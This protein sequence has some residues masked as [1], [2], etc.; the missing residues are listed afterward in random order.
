M[1]E[2]ESEDEILDRI[3]AALRKIGSVAGAVVPPVSGA[4]GEAVD[5]AALI[6]RLDGIIARLRDGLD[7]LAPRA[8]HAGPAR[9]A[10]TQSARDA[11]IQSSRDAHIQ[12][13]RDAHDTPAHDGLD[14]FQPEPGE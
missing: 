14:D 4:E 7:N 1:S 12:S 13:A 10:H 6:E 5:R 8:P 2:S 9:D 11:H 3:E